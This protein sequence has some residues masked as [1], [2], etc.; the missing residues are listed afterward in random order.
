MTFD[1]VLRCEARFSDMPKAE[2]AIFRAQLNLVLFMR[3]SHIVLHPSSFPNIAKIS[4]LYIQVLANALW[5][6]ALVN[7]SV[8]E[9]ESA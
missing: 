2:N 1:G 3:N 6:L 7:P 4:H 9:T 8:L 5:G